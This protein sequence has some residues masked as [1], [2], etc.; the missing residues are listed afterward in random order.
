MKLAV[1]AGSYTPG[2]ADQLRRDMAAWRSSGKIEAH[3][4]KLIPRM[5][6]NGIAPEFAERVFEQI[7]GFGEYGFPES[8]AASFA[9]IAYATAWM[10]CHYPDVFACALL[11]AWPM[12]F[13][14]PSTIVEDAKRHGVAILPVDVLKSE[15]ECTL[16]RLSPAG[17]S[18][19]GGARGRRVARGHAVAP[20]RRSVAPRW[21]VRMG[22]RFVKG[23][24]EEDYR[25]ILSARKTLEAGGGGRNGERGWAPESPSPADGTE[26]LSFFVKT[27]RVPRDSLIALAEA[28]AFRGFGH[29]RRDTLWLLLGSIGAAR[30]ARKADRFDGASLAGLDEEEGVEFR[31]LDPFQVIGWDYES[32]GHST[33]GHPMEPFRAQLR[34]R[35]LPDAR[36]LAELPDG[37]EASYVGLIICRQMPDN[38][39]GVLFVTM[40]DETGFVNLIVWPKTFE[41]YRALI[42]AS[43]FLGVTGKIQ[44][45]EG[46]V[47]LV[48]GS[49]W[50]AELSTPP[51][52]VSSRD[53][54]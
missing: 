49:F 50:Q 26:R 42:L 24:G 23:L 29:Y 18:S 2:E 4:E 25:R 40:E 31:R 43:P 36:G 52:P 32:S 14:L 3:R 51:T 38:A 13:Y 7:R 33:Y 53:F 21:G 19:I 35:R 54:H 45:A 34:A 8:H 27:A 1:I 11:N 15:W 17:R 37:T 16:E 20:T 47:H 41:R 46:V 12:G 44:A 30:S 28:G 48:A 9:I 10:K 5:V 39:A 22:L 6:A